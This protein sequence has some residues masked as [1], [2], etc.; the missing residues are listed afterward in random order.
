MKRLAILTS[1]GDAPGMNATIRAILNKSAHHDIE[2]VGVNYGFLGLVC[3]NFTSLDSERVNSS[4]AMGGTLLYSSRYPE[5]ADEEVQLKAIENLKEA[6]ID[7]LIVIGGCGSQNGALALANLGFPTIGIP[8]TIAN[9]IP[10]TEFTIGFDTAVNTV[11]SALDKIRDT[12]NSHVRTFVIEVKGLRSGDLALWSG[13]AGGA[14]SILIPEQTLDIAHVANKIKQ[15]VERKKK[16]CL[17]VLAEGVMSASELTAKLKDEGVLHIR[18]VELGHVPR[19]GSPSTYDRVLASKAG[20][21]AVNL[22]LEEQFGTCLCIQHNKLIPISLKD[23]LD[24]EKNFIDLSLSP[25]NASI[26]Y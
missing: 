18:E 22:F 1:G 25:L 15:S 7:G 13:V 26:S 16:H 2:I 4:I 3:K 8:A 12:A 19:G 6:K 20:A 23:A 21:N 10:G 17:I 24:I 11:V 9:D 14:E 5:F